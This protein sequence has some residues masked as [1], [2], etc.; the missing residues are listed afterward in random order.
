MYPGNGSFILVKG[1]RLHHPTLEDNLRTLFSK[2]S[3]FDCYFKRF[4]SCKANL[5]SVSYP[6]LFCTVLDRIERDCSVF[7]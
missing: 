7:V 2:G 4:V 3:L 5:F 6:V 1:V